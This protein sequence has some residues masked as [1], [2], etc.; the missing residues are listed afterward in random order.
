[1]SVYAEVVVEKKNGEKIS[2]SREVV[3]EDYNRGSVSVRSYNFYSIK[4]FAQFMEYFE[5]SKIIGYTDDGYDIDNFIG[6]IV[7]EYGEEY[8]P[9][10]EWYE[11]EE[12]CVMSGEDVALHFYPYIEDQKER[13][14]FIKK[15]RKIKNESEIDRIVIYEKNEE[16]EDDEYVISF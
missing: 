12:G 16:V 4:T 7:K 13:K 10:Q 3:Y 8:T 1:M 2:Y 9:D 14:S 15:L 11:D 5:E 6:K